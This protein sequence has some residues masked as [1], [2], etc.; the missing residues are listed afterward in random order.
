MIMQMAKEHHLIVPGTT[1]YQP[2]DFW[3]KVKVSLDAEGKL[4]GPKKD[5]DSKK[6][7][8]EDK[9]K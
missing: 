6:K 2:A 1:L 3:Q 7:D 5:G 4:D 8:K 9:K